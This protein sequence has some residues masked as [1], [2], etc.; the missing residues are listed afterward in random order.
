MRRSAPRSATIIRLD[1]IVPAK[2]KT[3]DEARTDVLAQ[4]KHDRAA[5][6]FGDLSRNRSR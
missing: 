5:D 4:L 6:K 3:F 2:G 1:D